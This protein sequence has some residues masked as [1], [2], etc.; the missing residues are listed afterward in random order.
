M[1]FFGAAAVDLFADARAGQGQRLQGGVVGV[2][3]GGHL[4]AHLA[5]DLDD[6]RDLLGPGDVGVGLGPGC[7]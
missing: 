7:R 2:G 5:V 3:G 1:T 6:Q 4:V